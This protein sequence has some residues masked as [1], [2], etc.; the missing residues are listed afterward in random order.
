MV[1]TTINLRKNTWEYVGTFPC[2][3]QVTGSSVEIQVTS[4][5][6]PNSS[7]GAVTLSGD[8]GFT[9]SDMQNSFSGVTSPS[10]VYAK[11]YSVGGRVSVSYA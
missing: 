6:E 10:A 3:L 8:F 4:G 11:C 7:E 5:A 1:H 9:E 2:R